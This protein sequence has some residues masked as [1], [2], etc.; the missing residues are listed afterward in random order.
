MDTDKRGLSDER[1]SRTFSYIKPLYNALGPKTT[2]CLITEELDYLD[3]N[4]CAVVTVTT[5]TP[6]VP[7]GSVFSTKTRYCFTW[8][9][10]NS[11]RIVM[12]YTIEWTG[13]SWIKGIVL[14]L[15]SVIVHTDIV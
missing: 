5:Q 9:P 8:G 11:T 2:K 10:K 7:S 1:R 15:A 4:K 13:K 3:Y 14:S 6:D 12:S